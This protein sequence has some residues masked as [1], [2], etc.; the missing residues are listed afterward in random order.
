MRSLHH[1]TQQLCVVLVLTCFY[2]WLLSLH[3]ILLHKFQQNLPHIFTVPSNS[4]LKS[5]PQFRRHFYSNSHSLVFIHTGSRL[6][7]IYIVT[8]LC[9]LPKNQLSAYRCI[10]LTICLSAYLCKS[11]IN[12]VFREKRY[13][14]LN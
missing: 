10:V 14:A 8:F 5:V 6:Y 4:R 7:N 11:A 13:R 2:F 3:D 12:A 1:C 9:S